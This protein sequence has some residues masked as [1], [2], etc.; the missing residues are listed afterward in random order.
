MIKCAVAAALGFVA[1][2]SSLLAQGSDLETLS[3]NPFQLLGEVNATSALALNRPDLFSS[4]N[5][6]S[7]LLH[8]LP[9]TT[10]LDGRRYPID[11]NLNRMGVL[12]LASLPMA[13][14][15]SV[16]VEKDG[17]A[18][19]YATDAAGGVV[20]FQLN[21]VTTGGEAGVFYG[22]SSGKYGREDFQAYIFGGVGTDKL[23]ISAGASYQK[24][25]GRGLLYNY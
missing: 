1:V 18:P 20:D 2:C 9:V 6:G 24:S 19:L 23:Q 13:F 15:Q 21:R 11:G 5:D 10:L 4:A 8:G 14:V 7:L 25:S 16:R 17:S 3:P 22:N 12:P